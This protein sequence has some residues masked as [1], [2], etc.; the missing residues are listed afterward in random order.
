MLTWEDANA[1]M[2]L[3]LSHYQVIR[4]NCAVVPF[5]P[6]KTAPGVVMRALG[7]ML[8]AKR[9]LASPNSVAQ[10]LQGGRQIKPQT[11]KL[12]GFFSAAK[13]NLRNAP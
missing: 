10:C 2:Y 8:G 12:N 1:S 5:D 9:N 11:S 7:L 3:P 6:S 4:R 13:T